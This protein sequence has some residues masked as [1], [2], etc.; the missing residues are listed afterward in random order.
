MHLRLCAA[1]HIFTALLLFTGC[2]SQTQDSNATAKNTTTPPAEAPAGDLQ[3]RLDAMVDETAQELDAATEGGATLALQEATG[4]VKTYCGDKKVADC[5][6]GKLNEIEAHHVFLIAQLESPTS[7][8]HKRLRDKGID[9][10]GAVFQAEEKA[11]IA[12]LGRLHSYVERI[13]KP[14]QALTKLSIITGSLEKQ[15]E[16]RPAVKEQVVG[17]LA[18]LTSFELK[19]RIVRKTVETTEKAAELK[20]SIKSEFSSFAGKIGGFF[21]GEEQKP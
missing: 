6:L 20:D 8:Y 9:V 17:A 11:M 1:P 3:T 19:L 2:K 18:E 21:S 14:L 12:G 16:K 5:I 4:D 15:I 10:D 7:T 13:N